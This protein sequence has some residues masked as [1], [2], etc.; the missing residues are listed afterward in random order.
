M[1]D[2]TQ[3]RHREVRLEWLRMISKQHITVFR[4]KKW[5]AIVPTLR[6]EI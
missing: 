4:G 5:D 3:F 6:F 2:I 1:G